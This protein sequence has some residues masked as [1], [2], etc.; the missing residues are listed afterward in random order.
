MSSLCSESGSE[1]SLLTEREKKQC[2]EYGREVA[3]IVMQMNHIPEMYRDRDYCRCVVDLRQLYKKFESR[4]A[5]W[6]DDKRREANE[7]VAEF[8]GNTD[9]GAVVDTAERALAGANGNTGSGGSS[10]NN[11][12]I[13]SFFAAFWEFVKENPKVVGAV[14]L[15]L[16][17]GGMCIYW[18]CEIVGFLW[19]LPKGTFGL[20][21]EF[22]VSLVERVSS[23]SLRDLRILVLR[24]L[25]TI[26]GLPEITE[27][28]VEC[29]NSLSGPLLLLLLLLLGSWPRNKN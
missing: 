3:A 2:E 5:S 27:P 13:S 23:L 16:L 17:G 20:L 1:E 28:L 4:I 8:V 6:P 10:G 22:C 18:R 26:F 9:L 24:E 21:K 25:K 12:G 14:A 11:G 29:V 7:I 15:I 19:R